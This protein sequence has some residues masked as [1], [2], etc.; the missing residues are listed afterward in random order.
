[1]IF[2]LLVGA[3]CG[4]ESPNRVP[5][6]APTTV[7]PPT[8]VPPPAVVV[9]NPGGL[10]G[11]VTDTGFRPIAGAMVE[12]LDGPQA[13]MTNTTNASGQFSLSGAFEVGT[14]VRA[15][16]EGYLDG[17]SQL[18]GPC[19]TCVPQFWVNISLGLMVAPANIAGEYTMTVEACDALPFEVRTRTFAAS[20]VPAADQP[21]A[22]NTRF[23]ADIGGAQ[24]LRGFAWEG[25]GIA[26]AG[27]YMEFWMG[28][29]HGQPGL[30]ERLDDDTYYSVDAWG[31]T[32]VGP[33]G[34]IIVSFLGDMVHCVLKPGE[35]VFDANGRYTCD[36]ARSVT[37]TACG[38]GRLTLT[39]R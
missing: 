15:K 3:A 14:R 20:I 1:M 33:G 23:R 9:P 31:T 34:T 32:T 39:K 24:L 25:I 38:A 4:S 17:T 13:G 18:M 29:Y 10:T 22:A 5:P 2:S 30:I 6:T 12:V 27:D 19:A 26:V 7:V 28:D 36:R 37:R 11:R 21:T 8:V 16:R 35:A